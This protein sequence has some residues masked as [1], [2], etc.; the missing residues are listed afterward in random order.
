MIT[1]ILFFI[2]YF[3]TIKF[4][5]GTRNEVGELLPLHFIPSIG[6]IMALFSSAFDQNMRKSLVLFLFGAVLNS[7]MYAGLC[8]G[9]WYL[10][11]SVSMFHDNLGVPKTG[12]FM[13]FSILLTI[14]FTVIMN[15]VWS[16][17][18]PHTHPTS[19]Q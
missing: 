7:A 14:F 2:A 13:T 1:A 18:S 19:E 10:T 8:F 3:V 5:P 15:A 17:F 12:W 4:I 11:K 9:A 6:I 16:T